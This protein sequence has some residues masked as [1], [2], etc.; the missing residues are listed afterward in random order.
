MK[1]VVFL[2]YLFIFFLYKPLGFSVQCNITPF[3]TLQIFAVELWRCKCCYRVNS[4]QENPEWILKE[5]LRGILSGKGKLLLL[6]S[7]HILW[8]ECSERERRGEWPLWPRPTVTCNHSRAC[9]R[10][11][12]FYIPLPA[13]YFF[14]V[15]S[16]CRCLLFLSVFLF[17]STAQLALGSSVY[18]ALWHGDG[19]KACG[20]G[21]RDVKWP[22]EGV[23]HISSVLK[24]TA[25]LST[26]AAT[27]KVRILT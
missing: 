22:L 25:L 21:S 18:S 1:F 8:H 26:L 15:P 3:W 17:R 19:E 12:L 11:Q 7:T 23:T 2:I 24:A 27:F 16:F 5:G 14:L 13:C 4:E 6:R 9:S 10:L 20:R